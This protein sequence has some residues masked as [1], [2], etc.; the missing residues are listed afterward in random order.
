M[1]A[2]LGSCSL[3]GLLIL[4]PLCITA[5][6]KVF[7]LDLTKVSG[8]SP[9]NLVRRGVVITNA[10]NDRFQYLASV[11]VGT[12]PQELALV[13]DM[14]SADTWL[15]SIG[16]NICNECNE[17]KEMCLKFGQCEKFHSF[18]KL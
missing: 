5:K 14:G 16:S 10:T 4:F 12:P 15:P 1:I 6:P 2:P 18:G 7:W 17:N 9:S 13:I 8:R 11:K 3:L